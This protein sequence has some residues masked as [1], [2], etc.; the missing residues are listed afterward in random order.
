MRLGEFDTTKER[1]CE[2]SD[3]EEYC[4]DQPIDVQ[5][6][7]LIP[8]ENYDPQNP[9]QHNDIALLRLSRDIA[10]T[11]FIRPICLP[12]DQRARSDL[13]ENKTMSV[14]GWGTLKKSQILN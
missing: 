5:I 1:D 7:R 4:S 10:S 8:H 2:V 14:A 13:L 11:R 12:I 6:E 3:G 9:N